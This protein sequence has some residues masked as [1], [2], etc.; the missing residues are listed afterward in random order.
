M[1]TMFASTAPATDNPATDRSSMWKPAVIAGL[2]AGALTTVIVALAR[3]A[4]IPVAVSGEEIPLMAFGQF[5]LIGALLGL[6]LAK[7]IRTRSL[8]P[9]HTF[10]R[11]TVALTALSIVPD[12][13]ANATPGSKLVLALTHIVAATVIVRTIARRLAR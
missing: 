3:A 11:T 4:D 5:T 6:G 10:L 7:L 13:I 8:H 12:I 9:H 1:T 2:A